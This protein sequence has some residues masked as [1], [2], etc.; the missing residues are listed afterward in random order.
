MAWSSAAYSAADQAAYTGNRPAV[1][2]NALRIGYPTPAPGLIW[3]NPGGLAYGYPTIGYS[4]LVDACL[5]RTYCVPIAQKSLHRYLSFDPLV[6]KTFDTVVLW[7]YDA[8]GY[9]CESVSVEVSDNDNGSGNWSSIKV[10]P[11]TGIPSL[12]YPLV[13]TCL[14]NTYP[15]GTQYPRTF[16]ARYIFLHFTGPGSSPCC[17]SLTEVWIGQRINLPFSSLPQDNVAVTSEYCEASTPRGSVARWGG[18]NG[19]RK[20]AADFQLEAA[21]TDDTSSDKLRAFCRDRDSFVWIPAQSEAAG[22]PEAYLMAQETPSTIE[23]VSPYERSLHIAGSEQ[24]PGHRAE[25]WPWS[26]L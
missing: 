9:N 8:Q 13:L 4:Y 16:S 18:Y 2:P 15:Y 11:L 24:G 26:T 22:N 14:N 19:K 7:G 25:V 17:P 21:T 20:L 10:Y 12:D 23:S 6:N 1:L 3:G 5:H